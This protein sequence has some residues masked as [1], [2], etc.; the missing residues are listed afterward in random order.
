MYHVAMFGSYIVSKTHQLLKICNYTLPC[1]SNGYMTQ[2]EVTLK[3]INM[4]TTIYL[5]VYTCKA[6]MLVYVT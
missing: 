2:H 5:A 4:H 3:C 1:N 6:D